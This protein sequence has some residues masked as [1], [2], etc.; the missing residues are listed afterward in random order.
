MRIPDV[1]FL[2]AERSPPSGLPDTFWEGAPD[3]AVEVLSPTD[4]SKD[5]YERVSDYLNAGAR[6]LWIIDPCS[7]AGL[8]YRSGDVFPSLIGIDDLFD[9]EDVLPGF[10]VT[11][12]DVLRR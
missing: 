4:R 9:G 8:V 3:L 10:R 7:E 12:H 5:I 1:W 11:L 2:R 6:L